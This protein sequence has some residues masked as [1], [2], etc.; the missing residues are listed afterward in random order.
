MTKYTESG[1][2]L[3]LREKEREMA[4]YKTVGDIRKV[5]VGRVLQYL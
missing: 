2:L 3:V 4:K 5:L 1:I